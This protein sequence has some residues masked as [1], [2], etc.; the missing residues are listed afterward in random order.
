MVCQEEVPGPERAR[1]L[2]RRGPPKAG[3]PA[4]APHTKMT[5]P[6]LLT[7]SQV[8]AFSNL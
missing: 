6:L 1:V 2:C 4:G 3:L 5:F 7:I 8:V